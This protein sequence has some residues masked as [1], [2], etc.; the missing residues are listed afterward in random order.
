MT[1]DDPGPGLPRTRNPSW[2]G[3]VLVAI[4]QLGNAIAGGNPDATI[5]ARV[6][7]FAGHH[8]QPLWPYWRLLERVIDFTFLPIDG[9]RH[10]HFAYL[11]DRQ[12]MREGSDL[13]RLV[14][15]LLIIVTCIP[16]SVITR[17]Y[18]KVFPRAKPDRDKRG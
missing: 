2:I 13:M 9:P 12:Q 11:K 17:L 5:S 18:V 3:G 6:G 14:L 10:C 1:P 16:L 4:D 15:S 8:E 7:Y